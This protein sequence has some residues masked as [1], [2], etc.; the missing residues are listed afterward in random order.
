MR[1]MV[2]TANSGRPPLAPGAGACGEIKD[3]SAA[4][5][6]TRFISSRNSRSR[7]F[8]AQA[9]E[10]VLAQA[11]L[12]NAVNV[13]HRAMGAGALQTLLKRVQRHVDTAISRLGT[14]ARC[15]HAQRMV[16]TAR[17]MARCLDSASFIFF[18]QAQKLVYTARLR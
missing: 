11:Q 12:L 5:G 2:L 8:K 1:S 18:T 9:L 7:V 14:D 17:G 15:I 16:G 3:T 4:Q 13:S 6:T 10:S